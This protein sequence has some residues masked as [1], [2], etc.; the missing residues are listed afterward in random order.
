MK[1][2][3]VLIFAIASVIVFAVLGVVLYKIIDNSKNKT[4]TISINMGYGE[5][6]VQEYSVGSSV[7]LEKE[8]TR[9]GYRFDGY[10]LD[11]HFTTEFD[12]KMAT[13]KDLTIYAKWVKDDD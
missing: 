9:E 6:L 1:K 11:E 8:P 4:I 7:V 3:S 13:K 12:Y 5:T 2:R 10:Y